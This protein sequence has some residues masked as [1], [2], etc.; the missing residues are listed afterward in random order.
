MIGV[1]ARKKGEISAK[2]RARIR[3][4]G[5]APSLMKTKEEWEEIILQRLAGILDGTAKTVPAD[6]AIRRIRAK[7]R[8][9]RG[10]H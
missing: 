2:E 1:M 5:P 8:R 3:K 9:L 7:L 4:L 10:G 6:V